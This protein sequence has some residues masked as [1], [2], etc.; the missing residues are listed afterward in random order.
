M[1]NTNNT[2]NSNKTNKALTAWVVE[3]DGKIYPNDIVG[4]RAYA[5]SIRNDVAEA[6]GSGA[7]VSVRKVVITQ[8]KGR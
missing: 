7:K 8:V 3:I 6:Y 2:N 1:K 4:T 5:R